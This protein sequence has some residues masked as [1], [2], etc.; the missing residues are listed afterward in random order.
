VTDVNIV[1]ESKALLAILVVSL[2]KVMEHG[3][4][5]HRLQQPLP[6]LLL[7]TRT[8]HVVLVGRAST[9]TN[10]ETLESQLVMQGNGPLENAEASMMMMMTIIMVMIMVMIVMMIVMK[11]PIVT[12]LVGIVASASDVQLKKAFSFIVITL[13]G[14]VIDG[15]DEHSE[16]ALLLI[17]L[18]L[19]GIVTDVSVVH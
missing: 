6:S 11:V 8:V 3:D 14:M 15:S 18:T 9:A 2:V 19:V 16:K 17:V 4:D 13:V 10:L 7:Q 12:T 5:V 1:H